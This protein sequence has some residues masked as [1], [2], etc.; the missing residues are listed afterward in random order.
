MLE[1]NIRRNHKEVK[2]TEQ[3]LKDV[4]SQAEDAR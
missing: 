2:S 4:R 3:Q 1:D